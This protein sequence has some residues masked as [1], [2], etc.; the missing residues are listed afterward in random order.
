MLPDFTVH[1]ILAI[2]AYTCSRSVLYGMKLF[3]VYD[4]LIS[5]IC[6]QQSIKLSS[7][8]ITCILTSGA[9]ATFTL[10]LKCTY[11]Y[12]GACLLGMNIDVKYSQCNL[13]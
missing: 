4:T 11:Y 9:C 10:K 3:H 2:T 1:V 7:L 5:R 6:K 8:G 13:C 12:Y